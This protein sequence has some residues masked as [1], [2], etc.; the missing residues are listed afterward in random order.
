MK[1]P[2][3]LKKRDDLK[4]AVSTFYREGSTADEVAAAGEKIIKGMYGA[5]KATQD[6]DSYRY[7]CFLKCVAGKTSQLA[8]LPPSEAA[9]R[10]HSFRAFFQI[11]TWLGKRCDPVKWGWRQTV[12][13]LQPV[14]TD[15]QPAPQEILKLIS[16]ACKKSCGVACG[17]RRAGLLC[18]SVRATCHGVCCLNASVITLGES[19]SDYSDDNPDDPDDPT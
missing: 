10:Q 2:T 19:E 3:V 7:E 13:G 8:S 9:A 6:L 16:C 15:L 5:T 1:L 18:S 17:C 12:N 11:Q 14:E 4:S